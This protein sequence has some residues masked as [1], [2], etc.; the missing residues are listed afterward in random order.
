MTIYKSTQFISYTEI[1]FDNYDLNL[2]HKWDIR[3]NR[4]AN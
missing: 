3:Y 1:E 2:L 4:T